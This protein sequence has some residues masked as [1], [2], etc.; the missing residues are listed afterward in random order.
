L[1]PHGN[2]TEPQASYTSG[3]A[4]T[5]PVVVVVVVAL[6]IHFVVDPDNLQAF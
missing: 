1:A 3:I 5:E 2:L 4:P 6:F